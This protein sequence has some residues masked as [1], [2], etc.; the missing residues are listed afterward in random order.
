LKVPIS[1]A[2]SGREL[3]VAATRLKPLV[4]VIPSAE[5]STP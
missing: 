4:G 3:M 1:G 5:V 2:V